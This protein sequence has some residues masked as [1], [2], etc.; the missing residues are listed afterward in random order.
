MKRNVFFAVLMAI[1]VVPFISNAQQKPFKLGL[2]VAPGIGWI[3]PDETTGYESEGA[4]FGLSWGFIS[5]FA[6]TDNYYVSTGFNYLANNGKLQ[7]NILQDIDGLKANKLTTRK[8]KLKYIEI[9]ITLKMKTNQFGALKYFGQIGFG[10]AFNVSAKGEDSF[11][12]TVMDL[13][14]SDDI[15]LFQAGFLFGGGGEFYLDKSTAISASLIFR[16]G[17]TDIL[18]AE[19]IAYDPVVEEKATPFTVQLCIGILF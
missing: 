5:D 1:M 3:N 2:Q 10:P 18:G 9:P 14:I 13:D 7:Y 6:L 16:K 8:Y 4:G 11:D 17:F 12:A 19:N 15:S